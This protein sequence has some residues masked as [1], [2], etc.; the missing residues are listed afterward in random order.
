VIEAAFM[1]GIFIS[2][3]RADSA[4]DAGRIADRLKAH[5]EPLGHQVFFDAEN[6]SKGADWRDVIRTAIDQS[7]VMLVLI[8]KDWLD[9][10]DD[11]GNKRLHNED[12]VVRYEIE[13]GLKK[14]SV[15]VI[16]VLLDDTAMPNVDAL[17]DD[18]H[19]LVDRNA[20][21]FRTDNQYFSRD[22][23]TLIASEIGRASC[24]ERV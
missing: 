11:D 6:I 19:E 5:F 7:S 12:D 18:L 22:A 17:P 16:P 15:T 21:F 3:R 2:Y 10:E 14:P 8:G 4:K 1:A 23:D 24:R 20:E 13:F 9:I